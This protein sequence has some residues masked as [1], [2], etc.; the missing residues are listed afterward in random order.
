MNEPQLSPV[1][2]PVTPEATELLDHT[3]N[4]S[5]DIT[6]LSELHRNSTP[7]PFDTLYDLMRHAAYEQVRTGGIDATLKRL[8]YFD[9][10][11]RRYAAE[12]V[13]DGDNAPADVHAALMQTRTSLLFDAGRYDEAM[14]TAAA[15]LSLLAQ[16]A[17]R[18]DEPF[19]C[20]LA[21]LLYDLARLHNVRDEYKQAER[22][23]D[24]SLKLFERL[25]A[26]N[27]ARYGA[28]HILS[29][30]G[31]TTLYRSRLK[32][33]NALA[34][35]QVATSSYMLEVDAG[36]EGALTHLAESLA[37]EGET[38]AKMNKHRE[39]IQ[40]FTR[41]LKYL[42]KIE[43]DFTS[44][45]LHMSVMLGESLLNIK[46]M[47]DKGVHLLNTMIQKANRLEEPE[48]RSRAEAALAR[49]RRGT[50]DILAIWHKLFPR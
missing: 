15:A 30:A 1:I 44:S 26:R 40:Y 33:T 11:L 3:V 50:T 22:C 49:T 17:K 5:L 16:E 19:L 13:R 23:I 28:A 29:M 27:P 7:L 36:V 48:W 2:L 47:R 37:R 39:A 41:A 9:V 4:L 34:H 45:Q 24:K 14:E 12:E 35:H 6:D 32:Q 43:P 20:I 25:A 38:L 21:L 46:T 10:L 31:V 18:K 42:T 8:D